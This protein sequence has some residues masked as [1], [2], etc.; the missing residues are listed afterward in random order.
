M[1]DGEAGE[2]AEGGGEAGRGCRSWWVWV[3]VGLL[4]AWLAGWSVSLWLFVVFV[5]TGD[6]S[7]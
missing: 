3:L 6:H 2:R 5:I 1:A 7:K 4:V